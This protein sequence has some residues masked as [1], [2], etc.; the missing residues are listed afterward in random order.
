MFFKAQMGDQSSSQINSF[1]PFSDSFHNENKTH[2]D[3]IFVEELLEEGNY[4]KKEKTTKLHHFM[5]NRIYDH[6][7]K[8]MCLQIFKIEGLEVKIMK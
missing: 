5:I 8:A 7:N 3:Q 6:Q 4:P 2:L 1:G